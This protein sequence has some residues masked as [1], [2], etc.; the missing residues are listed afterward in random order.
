MHSALRGSLLAVFAGFSLAIPSLEPLAASDFDIVLNEIQY[1]PLSGNSLDEYL[2]LYN[3]GATAVD[4]TD[5]SFQ[6]G[7][8]AVIPGGTVIEP[9][10]FLLLSPD[11][12]RTRAVHGNVD[13]VGPYVGNL[14]NGG[15]I[16]ALYNDE[17]DLIARVHYE[18]GG[19]W[20]SSPDGLGPTLELVDPLAQ[21]D[22]PHNWQ[23]SRI[24]NGTAGG[25]NS[26]LRGEIPVVS[27]TEIIGEAEFWRYLKGAGLED[28]PASWKTE[29]FDDSDWEEGR[30]GI[31]YAD[32]DDRTELLDMQGS[33][34]SIA[35]R[36]T[37]SMSQAEIDEAGDITFL[38]DFDDGFVAYLNGMELARA[39]VDG[40][41]GEDVRADQPANGSHEA[42]DFEVF[43][44]SKDLLQDGPNVLAVQVHNATLDSSDL[45][46]I[47]ML[48]I[49]E[50]PPSQPGG[51][52]TEAPVVI[53]EV[54]ATEAGGGGFI[55]LYN[56]SSELLAL[57]GYVLE[58]S[59]GVSRFTLPGASFLAT[60]EWLPILD[61]Q[62]GF[63]PALG[64]TYVLLEPDG[65]TYVD[66]LRTEAGEPGENGYSFGRFPDGDNDTFVMT[67]PTVG[68]ENTVIL[69]A[70]IVINEFYFH[71][72]YVAP[73]G[74]CLADCS[75]LEQWIELHNRGNTS[76]NLAGWSLTRA[77]TYNFGNV[78]M[79]AQSY[80]IVAASRTNFLASNP[81]VN[82]SIVVGGW[83]QALAHSSDIINLRDDLGNL[84]DHVKYGDGKPLNDEEPKD[85]VD[86]GTYR[87]SE[88]PPEADGT[89]RTVELI[90]P[91]L[92]NRDG[93]AWAAGPV[94]GTPGLQNS[95]FDATPL[96]IVGRVRHAPAVPRSDEE[97]TVTCRISSVGAIQVADLIWQRDGG[98]AGGTLALRDDGLSGDGR[99]GDG[100]YGARIPRQPTGAVVAYQILAD[101]QGSAAVTYPLPPANP[102][103]PA[104]AG[105]FYLYQVIDSPPLANPSPSYYI[106]M[107]QADRNELES[108]DLFSDVVLYC[109]FIAQPGAPDEAI[110]HLCGI[111]YRGSQARNT[112]PRPYRVNLP[113]ENDYQ[114]IRR[115]NLN[116]NEAEHEILAG[117][118]FQR[119]G[120]P[121]PLNWTVNLTFQGTLDPRYVRKEHL[122]GDFLD[123]VFGGSD[124]G[125]LYRA[126]DPD[127]GG[128]PFQGDLSYLGEDPAEYV[129]YYEKRNNEEEA[130]YSDIIELTRVFDP[131]QTPDAEFPD[132]LEEIVDVSQWARFFAA[133]SSIANED[134]SIQNFTGE[135]YFLYKVPADSPRGDRGK[136]LLV[137]WDIE[138][139]YQNDDEPLFRSQLPAVRRFFTHQRYAPLMYCHHVNLRNG[140]F[141]RAQTRQRFRLIDFLY[142]FSTIDRIDTYITTRLGFFDENI[143]MEIT[144]GTA[145]AGGEGEALISAGEDWQFFRGLGEPSGGTTEWARNSF[146]DG[147]W[148][149]GP[150]GIGYGDADDATVL[151]DMQ[152][153][154]S[155]VYLRRHFSVADPGSVFRLTLRVDYDDAFVA[156]V[157]R[158]EVARRG[159]FVGEYGAGVPIG[160]AEP[161][162]FDAITISNHEASGG[163]GGG[164]P[165]EEID[166]SQFIGILVQGEDN[167]LAI[168][169]VNAGLGSSDLS[170]IPELFVS[171][172]GS[173]GGLGCGDVLYSTD[174]SF[175]V[176]GRADA[177]AT[178][179][180]EV[181]GVDAAYDTFLARWSRSGVPLQLGANTVVIRAFDELGQVSESKSVTVHR[182]GGSFTDVGGPLAADTVW[183]AAGGPYL[184]TGNVTVPAGV[185][186]RIL[187]GT[188]IFGQSGA[189]IIVQGE[190]DAQGSQV[191]PIIF[192]AAS[193]DNRWGGIGLEATGTDA[194]SFTHIIRWCDLEYG[195]VAPGFTGNVSPRAARVLVDHSK[196][197]FVTANAVDGVDARVE[198]RDSSFQNIHEGVHC[199]NS[200][201]IVVGSMFQGMVGDSDAIDFDG[202]GTERSLIEG[203]MIFD[204]SD[205]GV[206]LL[207]TS[208][209]IRDNVFSNVQDKALSLEENGPLGPPTA[210]GNVIVNCGTGMALKNGVTLDVAH[211]N[212]V[213]GNQEGINLFSKDGFPDGGHGM[214]HSMIVWDNSVDVKIDDRSTASFTY[215][216]ISDALWPGTGNISLDPRFVDA[217]GL[218]YSLEPGSPCITTGLASTDMGAIPFTGQVT[219]FIRADADGSTMINLND[220]LATLDYLFQNGAAPSCLDRM[221]ANDDSVVDISDPLYTIFYLFEEGPLPPAPFPNAGV[222]PTPDAIPCE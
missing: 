178:R 126:I 173:T 106:V 45:S 184:M 207:Q 143:P 119:A 211:H 168:Q 197:N 20:A 53:N 90:H 109:T 163:G 145:G 121:G 155:T 217:A 77:V 153:G 189:S 22:V 212:T 176:S 2:E 97:V 135:D 157:N 196:F 30:T 112:I 105:P 19:A 107:T 164:Q 15:E 76:V 110:R 122:D 181:N 38:L 111:R 21:A 148:E 183:N 96:A 208:V 31:G 72:P 149:V 216:D 209:D 24:L 203:C 133:Q 80:L 41:I 167:V 128:F 49:R 37:F 16:L 87:G 44:V 152:D 58:D 7:V 13:V 194:G 81:A 213:V 4:L 64:E 174:S 88:W 161:V 188:V 179:R 186:L 33:Y 114:G 130:D 144:A 43:G 63:D 54:K 129:P 102:P 220:S 206:D 193:C 74:T 134:G 11:P 66:A 70:R 18:D 198:V 169:V 50:Q 12:A 159:D 162:P 200:T 55:E 108:R 42:G 166:I 221:D 3:R 93:Y 123:R 127:D 117:D 210:T 182:I 147:D 67:V 199:T 61:A 170:M 165:P 185:R 156:Y 75:D 39:N 5:W 59:G 78:V 146:D 190:L 25:E 150:S 95:I 222:D 17:G 205:D 69:E 218:D 214:F 27:Q 219:V 187:P 191:Q 104:F 35:A 124:D 71:P 103:H 215:S 62:L 138:E 101:A 47:P 113:S 195:G 192:R 116:S 32:G 100:I 160:P 6:E 82:P 29:G 140:T 68:F 151:T 115:L 141:S 177:C 84:V 125:N 8:V 98:G 201:V 65:R 136:W 86:D 57:D 85:E 142:P 99:A 120:I 60:G 52:P 34:V 92:D 23:A 26:T 202:N 46:F 154:Y 180:V 1:N 171:S 36:K 51:G 73:G 83:Q 131:G 158:T 48:V 9:K 204:G 14:D 40:V 94:G 175:E 132:R 89:G 56:R 172:G 91:A 137:P 79:P 139:S 10:E 28:Y 118:F